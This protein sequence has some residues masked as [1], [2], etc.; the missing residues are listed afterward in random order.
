MFNEPNCDKRGHD[1]KKYF[2]TQIYFRTFDIIIQRLNQCFGY[3][4]YI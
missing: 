2:K 4:L 1:L 3:E